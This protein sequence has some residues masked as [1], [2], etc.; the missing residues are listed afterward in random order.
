M[1]NSLINPDIAPVPCEKR[2]WS[3]LHFFSLWVGMAVCIPTYMLA[4]SLIDGGM[5][6]SQAILTVLLGNSIVLIPMILNGH[7]G[8]KYGIPYP[9]FARASFGIRGSNIAAM[10]RAIV[11]CGWFGIQTWI[12]GAAIYSAVLV[13]WPEAANLPTVLPEF[14]GVGLVPFLCFLLFWLINLY[15]IWKGTESI[16]WLETACAPF[17]ILCGLAL[18][19]W[20]IMKADG[21]GPILSSPSRFETSDA[22]WAFFVPGLTGMVGFWATL[23]LNITDFTRYAAN[24]KSQVV[25]QALGLPTTMTLFAFIGVVVT[26]ATVILYGEAIWD[27]VL[28]VRRFDSPMIVL[29]SMFAVLIATLSTNVAA[30]VV[31]PANDFSNLSPSRIS[32]KQGGYITGLIGILM[33]PWKLVK[34]P[35][36]YI[37]T[38]LIGYSALLGPI[39]GILLVDYYLVRRCELSVNDLYR[40]GGAYWYRNGINWRAVV[41][42]LLG[43]LPNLPGFLTQVKVLDLSN[44]P[45]LISFYHYAWFI[46]FFLAGVSYYLFSL[47]ERTEAEGETETEE[48]TV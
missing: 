26:S 40:R 19:G 35:S 30:N 37:F 22:F 15:F 11:A 13:L 24:Q 25:G 46:G 48:V 36:G 8:V 44:Y 28:L 4:S 21:L 23:S 5:N 39:G 6:W 29:V 33:M 17:L 45:L 14:I 43:V 38:W 1:E 20:A 16:K 31:G 42:F 34:D 47:I 7:V 3:A 2:T 12:G 18:L 27:P 10:L 9:V 41:A 32:F